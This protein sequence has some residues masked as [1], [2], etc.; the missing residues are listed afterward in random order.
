MWDFFMTIWRDRPHYCQETGQ[1]LG[2]EPKWTMFHHLIHKAP[3]PEFKY[4]VWNIALLHPDIHELVHQNL[5][6]TPT[7]KRLT[8]QAWQRVTSTSD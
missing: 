5:D 7:V 4:E 2:N 6:A 3:Y 1:W 8:E